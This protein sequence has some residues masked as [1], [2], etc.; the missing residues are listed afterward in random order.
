[1]NKNRSILV[2]TLAIVALAATIFVG[3]KKE[4]NETI[5]NA[6]TNPEAQVWQNR[7]RHFQELR[8]A[9]EAGLKSEG[10]MTL[11]EMRQTL[12]LMANYEHSQY[13]I[14]C[15]NSILD[16]LRVPMIN[17][18]AEGNVNDADVMDVYNA[19]EKAL[20]DRMEN[21][22]DGKDILGLFGVNVPCVEEKDEDDI[23]IVFTRGQED[24]PNPDLPLVNGPF[25][26]IC[27]V[28][29]LDLGYC[30]PTPQYNITWDA[31]DELSAQF[32]PA[33]TYPGSGIYAITDVEYV[34]YI[35]TQTFMVPNPEI[36]NYT[37]WNPNTS[38]SPCPY[39][40]F[41][42][43]GY[44]TDEPC[45][46]EDELNCEW[47]NINRFIVLDDGELHYSPNYNSPYY[48]C[49]I[50]DRFLRSKE[51]DEICDRYHTARVCYA[52]VQWE[53]P[54]PD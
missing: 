6:K 20:Q 24:E 12:G 45:L 21:I 41:Y 10:T 11:E 27:L 52:K 47:F 28:W 1:M 25:K 15:H 30:N 50:Y 14:F 31:A 32:T 49:I 37:Y 2:A 18:D 38:I 5:S 53:G 54:Y 40:L 16:T 43:S 17:V 46:C 8:K 36:S 33:N 29:G 48:S 26:D 19:F 39:W 22:N 9:Y 3:C 35:A 44:L 34:E 42:Q 23:Q 7:I 13:E 4:K 51:P